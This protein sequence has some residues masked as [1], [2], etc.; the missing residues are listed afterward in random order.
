MINQPA[1]NH[2]PEE[3]N[4]PTVF[5]CEEN[6]V[7]TVV[8][9]GDIWFVAEDVCQVLGLTD[10]TSA[11]R[12]L[13]PDEKGPQTL[14]TLGGDQNLKIV[15][16]PGLYKLLMRSSKPASKRFDR[17]VRHDVLPEIVRTGRYETKPQDKN[18]Y[19]ESLPQDDGNG[20]GYRIVLPDYGR[21]TITVKPGGIFIHRG[22]FD[23][24]LAQDDELTAQLLCYNLKSVETL[25]LKLRLRQAID[26]LSL[27]NLE[28]LELA[29]V[30]GGKLASHYLRCSEMRKDQAAPASSTSAH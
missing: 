2:E 9:D 5:K 23:T 6:E 26:L 7:R 30:K 8:K 20:G 15:S 19:P 13:D 10:V 24:M 22:D 11:L 3:I 21:Y 4:L 17:W 27:P 28:Q 14:R 25:W 12:K 16:E 18:S 1:G 29:I